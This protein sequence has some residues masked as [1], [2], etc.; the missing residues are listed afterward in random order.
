MTQQNSTE[1]PCKHLISERKAGEFRRLVQFAN[2]VLRDSVVASCDGGILHVT[3]KKSQVE[4]RKDVAV[5]W[6]SSIVL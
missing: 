1:N 3:V 5:D 2:P 4:E 6:V